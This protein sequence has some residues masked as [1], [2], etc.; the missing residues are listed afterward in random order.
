MAVGKI[1]PHEEKIMKIAHTAM[2]CHDIEVIK[3]FYVKYFG[4]FPG[5][6]Y[7]NRKTNFTSRFLSFPG[8]D[9]K[10]E[11]MNAPD[12]RECAAE[13][14]VRGFCHMALSIGSKEK[15]DSLTEILRRDGFEILSEPRTTGDGY[16]ESTVKDPEG[17]IIELTI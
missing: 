11:L 16:Y 8:S 4:A 12:I 13:H 3:D 6:L 7:H 10:L 15:V 2:W 5:D 14:R 1:S 9:V 17:N